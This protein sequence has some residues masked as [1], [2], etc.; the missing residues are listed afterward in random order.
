MKTLWLLFISIF[1][2][3]CGVGHQD[4][5]DIQNNHIGT[6][7]PYLTPYRNPNAGKKIGV[8]LIVGDGLTHITYNKDGDMV[9]HYYDSEIL[10][11]KNYKNAKGKCKFYEIVDPKTRIIKSWGI[12]VL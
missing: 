9:Y 1:F 10:E 8:L 3:G 12:I 5:V 4:W 7:A 6:K 2:I 11:H